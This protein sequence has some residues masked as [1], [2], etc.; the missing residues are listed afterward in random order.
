MGWLVF[1]IAIIVLFSVFFTCMARFAVRPKVHTLEHELEF[2]KKLDYMQGESIEIEQEHTITTYDGQKLWVGFV[3]GDPE[4]RHYVVLSHGYTSTRYGMYK[5]AVLWRKL[6]YNCVIYDNRGHGVNVPS[7]VTFGFKESKDLMAVIEDTYKR[8]GEDIQIGLHG[9]S[10]GAGLQ[11]MALSYKPE[12]DFIINDCGYSELLP[13]LRWKVNQ[14]FHLPRWL[15]DAASPFGRL[16]YGFWFQE[17]RPIDCLKDN[18]IPICFVHGTKDSFTAHWHSEKMYEVNKGY[19][20]LH[21]Y[22]GVDH[23]ECVVSDPERYLKMLDK[24]VRK[25]YE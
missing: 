15:A 6:G 16:M 5:Y 21:L 18:E 8:F 22:K 9:E 17:I 14:A 10:M 2:L 4:N 3:P 1:I 25:V 20:E 23:A 19:K 11:L 12:V 24:F 13:V 7:T